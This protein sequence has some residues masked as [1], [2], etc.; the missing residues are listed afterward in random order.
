MRF[1]GTDLAPYM[2]LIKTDELLA[3][4]IHKVDR[5]VKVVS[6]STT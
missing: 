1:G 2:Q 6:V 3:Q 5:I 4:K